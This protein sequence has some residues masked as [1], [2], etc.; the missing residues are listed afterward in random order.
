MRTVAVTFWPR[1]ATRT[2]PKPICPS[3]LAVTLPAAST[4]NGA[5]APAEYCVRGSSANDG[6]VLDA[7]FNAT[8]SCVVLAKPAPAFVAASPVHTMNVCAADTMSASA[9]GGDTARLM[10]VDAY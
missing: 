9:V 7:Y 3:A 10:L 5:S 1:N 8:L 6:T 2:S 4:A